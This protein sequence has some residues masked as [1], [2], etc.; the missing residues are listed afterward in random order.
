MN[1]VLWYVGR[2]RPLA[3]F[4]IPG[5]LLLAAGLIVGVSV[6]ARA[7]VSVFLCLG[8]AMTVYAGLVLSTIGKLEAKLEGKRAAADESLAPSQESTSLSP[9]WLLLLFGVPGMLALLAGLA[10]GVWAV[11]LLYTKRAVLYGSYIA[12]ASLTV[13]G[14]MTWLTGVVLHALHD[15]PARV[16]EPEDTIT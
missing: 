7:L 8:G 16:H 2:R 5:M 11:S 9:A 1:R 15:I 4:G 14:L 6:L 3:F 13:A 12:S 10:W